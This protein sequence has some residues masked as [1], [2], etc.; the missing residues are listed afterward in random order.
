[1]GKAVNSPRRT[2]QGPTRYIS[3]SEEHQLW[4]FLEK[5]LEFEARDDAESPTNQSSKSC[6]RAG[7]IVM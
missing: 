2:Q 6:K 4:G 5:D 3:T 7:E 1:M